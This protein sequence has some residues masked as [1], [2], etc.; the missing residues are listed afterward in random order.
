MSLV[1][2]FK[3]VDISTNHLTS[4]QEVTQ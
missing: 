1:I 3:K 4:I 2:S